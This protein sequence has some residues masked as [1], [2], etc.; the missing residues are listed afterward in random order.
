MRKEAFILNLCGELEQEVLA[1][2]ESRNLEVID[3]RAQEGSRDWTHILTQDINDFNFI[4]ETYQTIENDIQIVSLTPINDKQNFVL[5]NGKLCLDKEW[6]KSELRDFLLDKFFQSYIDTN[7]LSDNYAFNELGHFSVNQFFS[8]GDQLDHLAKISFESGISGVAVRSYIDHLVMYMAA[9][10]NDSKM[11]LPAEISFGDSELAFGVQIFFSAK[12]LMLDDVAHCLSSQ[13]SKNAEENILSNALSFCD[14][15][16]LSLIANAH[17]I[18]ITALWIKN[19]QASTPGLMLSWLPPKAKIVSYISDEL[20]VKNEKTLDPSELIYLPSSHNEGSDKREVSRESF[21]EIVSTRIAQQIE[22]EKVRKLL[23]KEVSDQE[24]INILENNIED[25]GNQILRGSSLE[26]EVTTQI[27]SGAFDDTIDNL[28]KDFYREDEFVDQFVRILRESNPGLLDEKTWEILPASLQ[29]SFNSFCQ[30]KMIVRDHLSS[31]QIKEFKQY[32][33]HEALPKKVSVLSENEKGFIK[34]LRNRMERNL[35]TEFQEENVKVLMEQI[36]DSKPDLVRLKSIFKDALKDSLEA[37][38]E[39]SHNGFISK[40]QESVIVKSLSASLEEDK[41]IIK[42]ILSNEEGVK[43]YHPLFASQIS[44]KEKALN[45]KLEALEQ[46][47]KSLRDK[48]QALT[49]ELRALKE[50]KSTVAA[51]QSKVEEVSSA[52]RQHHSLDE[53]VV[54][55]KQ[56]QEKLNSKTFNDEDKKRLNELLEKELALTTAVREEAIQAKKLEIELSQKEAL[57]SSEIEKLNRQ[58]KARDLILSKS[59]ESMLKLVE[60]K[61]LEIEA[62]KNKLNQAQIQLRQESSNI[63]AVENKHLNV[64][65]ENLKKQLEI[66]KNKVKTLTQNLQNKEEVHSSK[67]ELRKLQTDKIQLENQLNQNK[68]ELQRSNSLLTREQNTTKELKQENAE[69]REKI[70]LLEKESHER[71]E[72]DAPVEAQV[73]NSVNENE[74]AQQTKIKTLEA[75]IAELEAKL[76][77]AHKLQRSSAVDEKKIAHLE[78]NLKKL[79]QDIIDARNQNNELRKENNKLR[80]E[81]T[82]MKNEVERLKKEKMKGKKAA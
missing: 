14:F 68:K 75:H 4:R 1:Y 31:E 45:V 76:L 15:F 57:F 77:E 24:I 18:S 58:L 39:F 10:K 72:V 74:V 34:D 60:K 63:H 50:S 64:Q 35:S 2:F 43:P 27:I 9:L 56:I 16:D 25:E 7:I 78:T 70:K 69:L 82:A 53:G 8:F 71:K 73:Q 49:M 42:E 26:E 32:F 67:D 3:P 13:L 33:L 61:N 41:Q 54:V 59:K 46:E 81:K 5:A 6:L 65:N 52:S 40:H 66:Y 48:I 17:K 12:N 44:E 20:A 80:S 55:K 22:P 62:I 47:K 21:S 36:K 30:A 19:A 28:K 23:E 11:E 29:E 37:K 38:F 51:I 79:T